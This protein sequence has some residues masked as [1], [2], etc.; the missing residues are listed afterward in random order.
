MNVTKSDQEPTTPST[1]TS[2]TTTTTS[3]DMFRISISDDETEHPYYTSHIFQQTLSP[4]ESMQSEISYVPSPLSVVPSTV[5]IQSVQN[6]E[7]VHGD[8]IPVSRCFSPSRLR[9]SSP[10]R[11][12]ITNQ[13]KAFLQNSNFA[14]T[15]SAMENKNSSNL[16]ILTRERSLGKINI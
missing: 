6:I 2:I 3:N 4:I 14:K 15:V 10:L 11:A 16:R 7:D 9:K 8:Y 5:S 1:N 12:A 13:Q